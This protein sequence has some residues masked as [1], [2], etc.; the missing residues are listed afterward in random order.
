MAG[1]LS[2]AFRLSEDQPW[3]A[4]DLCSAL[5]C[6]ELSVDRFGVLKMPQDG[7]TIFVTAREYRRSCP[8]RLRS[9]EAMESKPEHIVS[10]QKMEH[11][12]TRKIPVVWLE[13]ERRSNV[14]KRLFL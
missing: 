13:S 3:I 11:G 7:K 5:C 4:A 9:C 14:Q 2:K 12:V 6:A 1:V 10:R 8:L